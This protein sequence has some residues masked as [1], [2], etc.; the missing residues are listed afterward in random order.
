VSATPNKEGIRETIA[1]AVVGWCMERAWLVVTVALLLTVASAW[2]AAQLDVVT[3]LKKLIPEH[4]PSVVRL[5]ELDERAGNQSDIVVTVESSDPA[6]NIRYGQR[7]TE[8]FEKDERIRFVR[9]RRDVSSLEERALLY[10]TV[11][12]L[13]DVRLEVIERIK[14]EVSKELDLG[15]DDDDDEPAGQ[16]AVAPGPAGPKGETEKAL[17]AFEDDADFDAP[18]PPPAPAAAAA[19][20][21]PGK[22]A[23][24]KAL[25]DFEDDADF[26]E[27]APAPER[28]GRA[29]AGGGGGDETLDVEELKEKYGYEEPP[30]YYTNDDG[31]LLVIRARPFEGTADTSMARQLTRMAREF[32]EQARAAD[33]PADLKLT[34][35][36]HHLDRT[37]EVKSIQGNMALSASVCL[38]LLLLAIGIYFRRP[39]AVLLVAT[40]LVMSV[41]WSLGLAWVFYG[42]L[43]IISA[44]IF[45][46]LLGLGIDYGIHVLARYGE[47]RRAGLDAR[48]GMR[49]ALCT[50]GL[51]ALTGALTTSVVFFLLTFGDFQGFAQFGL[52]AGCGVLIACLSVFT[53][54]P[55]MVEL[56][57]R[58]KPWKSPTPVLPGG[59]STP[60]RRYWGPTG[61]FAHAVA[62]VAFGT[63]VLLAVL[64][65][66]RLDRVEFEYAFSELGSRSKLAAE[67]ELEEQRAAAKAAG[68]EFDDPEAYKDVVG[69]H[70]LG[71]PTIVMTRD[72]A[73]TE[74]LYRQFEAMRELPGAVK[75]ALFAARTPAEVRPP[76]L[77]AAVAGLPPGSHDR[78]RYDEAL[79]EVDAL[80]T[81]YPLERAQVMVERLYEALSIFKFVP[82][83]QDEKFPIIEDIRRR[84]EAKKEVF[85]G[86][87]RERIDEFMKYLSPTPLAVADLPEWIRV[88]FREP[89]GQEGRFLVLYT[90]GSKSDII[91]TLALKRSYFDLVDP[92]TK[93]V[94]PTAATYYVLPEIMETIADEGPLII[95]LALGG[96]MLLL[97]IFFR[98][99]LPVLATVTPLLF[100]VVWAVG[101]M[102]LIGLKLN[103][104]NVIV[105]PLLLG[106]GI[107]HGVHMY[108]RF[109][110]QGRTGLMKIIHETGGAIFMATVTT[111]IG[112][113]GMFFADHVGL[114]TMGELAM[115]G[116]ALAFVAAV[117]TLPGL[118]HITRAIRQARTRRRAAAA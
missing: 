15:L 27:P 74:R 34:L 25:D 1:A 81:I 97:F 3:D 110:E 31:T 17:D 53:V 68:E 112:F 32:I 71:A 40:P 73:Q 117:V 90:K 76:E 16:P 5:D 33:D 51:S 48:R 69:R 39:R 7:L 109:V 63:S 4:F 99:V 96:L 104:Y 43:N 118:L 13:E 30:E 86:K 11:P 52:V 28:A 6:A 105:V 42:F 77:M 37:E 85:E 116:M 67:R 35:S 47:A 49:L 26:G 95:G 12:Q 2:A 23:T 102:P 92:L 101:L 107:D 45:A 93:E 38:A 60:G 66:A 84:L 41:V 57:E 54:L 87:D 59:T 78:H 115:I 79:A 36:G 62:G 10:L 88:Q 46:V 18:S 56:L 21:R 94:V 14:K 64:A 9:F 108:S 111:I 20:A 65:V 58:A 89:R 113:G 8:R 103:F 75:A 80:L 82:R 114:E 72:V 44:F 83:Q 70:T 91:N 24:E 19:A 61:R 106:M 22:G 29:G 50:T 55:A 98:G 100:A